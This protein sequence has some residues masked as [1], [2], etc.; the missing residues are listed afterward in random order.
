LRGC[1]FRISSSS[2]TATFVRLD[3]VG[4]ILYT[5]IFEDCN[6]VAS[7]DAAGGI[8]LAEASQTGTGT[9]KGSLLYVRPAALNVTDFATA[10]G[11]RN[12]ATQVVA[13]VSVAAAIEG[14]TPTA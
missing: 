3:A 4:D 5:N 1:T 6:F 8:A 2:A 13:A 9:S 10:T 7:V 14:I 11:G 12:A